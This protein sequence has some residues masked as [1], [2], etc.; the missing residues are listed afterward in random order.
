MVQGSSKLSSRPGAIKKV[1]KSAK[2]TKQI[3]KDKKVK[4]GNPLQLPTRNFRDEALDD[5]SLSKAIDKSNERKVAAK[6]IQGGGKLST[7]DLLQKGK[8]LN[9][10]IRRSQVKKK[11]GRVSE[12][13]KV[14]QE[15]AEKDGLM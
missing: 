4:K 15:K 10:D 8:E 5:H 7:T 9:K 6:L 13:L 1:G 2:I 3:L 11:V 14:L 12:K